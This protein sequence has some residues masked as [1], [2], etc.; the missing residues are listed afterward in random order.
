MTAATDVYSCDD[1]LD[2]SAVPPDGL[3]VA[4]AARAAPSAA[5][6]SSTRA[7]AR[8]WVCEGRVIGRSGMPKNT[9]LVKKLSAIGR[10]GIEDDGYR[11]GHAAAAPRRTWT[12][13]GWPRR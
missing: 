7:R 11:A 6:A 9:E 1:H 2:L 10:A 5:R 4:A 3:G 12:A 8:M 13:T